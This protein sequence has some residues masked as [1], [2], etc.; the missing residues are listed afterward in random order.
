MTAKASESKR[1][2]SPAR[3]L[4]VQALCVTA[5]VGWLAEPENGGGQQ[6]NKRSRESAPE[7]SFSNVGSPE[8]VV[9]MARP[10]V[11]TTALQR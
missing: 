4:R 11:P 8:G 10:L 5:T 2:V 7:R 9:R 1:P 3:S 6:I